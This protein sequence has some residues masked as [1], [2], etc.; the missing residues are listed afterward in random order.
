M[1]FDHLVVGIV[2]ISISGYRYFYQ[3]YSLLGEPELAPLV[4]FK[5]LLNNTN[6]FS[7]IGFFQGQLSKNKGVPCV[8]V[9]VYFSS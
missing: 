7:R 2:K 6:W 4:V 8:I 3:V 9:S 5:N 1:G